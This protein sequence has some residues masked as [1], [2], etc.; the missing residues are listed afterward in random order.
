VSLP[1]IRDGTAGDCEA[2]AG[3]VRDLARLAHVEAGITGAIL[4][5]EAFGARPTLAFLVAEAA[6]EIVGCLVHQD[7]FSTWR[8]ANGVFV[9]DLFVAPDRRGR[10]LGRRLLA[11]AARR[12]RRRGAAFMRLDVEPDNEA[13]LRF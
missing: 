11:E 12:G 5:R 6:G 2:V 8:G 9:V 7:S 3:L 4:A 1:F 13:A 10:G